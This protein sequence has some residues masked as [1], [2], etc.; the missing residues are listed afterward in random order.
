M[1]SYNKQTDKI[2]ESNQNKPMWWADDDDDV[3]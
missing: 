3:G 2:K 1:I